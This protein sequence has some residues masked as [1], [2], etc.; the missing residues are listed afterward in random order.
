[1]Q[2]KNN[3]SKK[4]TSNTRHSVHEWAA[5]QP[6][7]LW[8]FD[9]PVAAGKERY[10]GE[11]DRQISAWLIREGGARIKA[12]GVEITAGPGEWLFCQGRN[13]FQEIEAGTVL[14]SIR[15]QLGWPNYKPMFEGGPVQVFDAAAHPS[16]ERCAKTLLKFAGH[17]H[18]DA[19]FRYLTDQ[20]VDFHAYVRY[21]SA[22]MHWIA[23]LVKALHAQGVDIQ[24]AHLDDDRL[25]RCC[26]LLDTLPPGEPFPSEA[27]EQIAGISL[28]QIN[29]LCRAEH[30]CSL[31][32]YRKRRRLER[33]A[34][35]LKDP[36]IP[37]KEIAYNLGFIQLS[38]FSAWFK[39]HTEKAPRDYR[40]SHT[41]NPSRSRRNSED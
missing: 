38:H 1:M 13:V 3:G 19:P 5:L 8:I 11:R 40:Q 21:E 18:W 22:L 36:S 16:V 39:R 32:T 4:K 37:I 26:K 25:A 6:D 14:L 29:R 20:R 15:C 12:D 24:P 23:S 35:Q 2:Q 34:I 30:G 7:L 33:A 41:P 10:S 31:Q 28:S 9:A 17:I 27:I